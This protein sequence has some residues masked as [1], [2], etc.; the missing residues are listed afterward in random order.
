MEPRSC[1][2]GYRRGPG[3]VVVQDGRPHSE[4]ANYTFGE[5]EAA[6]YLEKVA[7]TADATKKLIENWESRFKL[8]E[9]G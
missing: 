3:F 4:R 5:R 2:T 6:V 9:V 1:W 7:P 8:I